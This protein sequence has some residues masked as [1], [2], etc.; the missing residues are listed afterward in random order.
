MNAKDA[1]STACVGLSWIISSYSSGAG[2]E[3][4]EVAHTPAD[5]YVRDSKTPTGPSLTVPAR[6]WSTFIVFASQ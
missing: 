6:A 1:G 3:C 4:V 2:G 5:T